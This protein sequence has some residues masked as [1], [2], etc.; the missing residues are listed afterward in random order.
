[1][2]NLVK[3]QQQTNNNPYN[4]KCIVFENSV[5]A[6]VHAVLCVHFNIDHLIELVK[7]LV[8]MKAT[9]LHP[10]VNIQHF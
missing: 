7:E 4:K 9:S 1:M 8:C 2:L 3:E 6:L 10:I 5:R